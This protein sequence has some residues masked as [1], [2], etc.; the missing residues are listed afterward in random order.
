MVA[1]EIGRYSSTPSGE[2]NTDGKDLS[3]E[4]RRSKSRF[5][6]SAQSKL[7]SQNA[8]IYHI[9]F[10]PLDPSLVHRLY[11]NHKLN[12]RVVKGLIFGAVGLQ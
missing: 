5:A 7:R 2:K 6:K 10:T 8:H 11:L 12:A 3:Q 9:C 1:A 4:A